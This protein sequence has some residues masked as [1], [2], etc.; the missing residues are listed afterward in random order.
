VCVCVAGQPM[1]GN[2]SMWVGVIGRGEPV[3]TSPLSLPSHTPDARVVLGP[4]LWLSL[5]HALSVLTSLRA[6]QSLCLS[7]RPS[8]LS[9]AVL[10]VIDCL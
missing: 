4:S 1:V 10:C 8:P 3:A 7:C 6:A 5:S 9:A 2:W